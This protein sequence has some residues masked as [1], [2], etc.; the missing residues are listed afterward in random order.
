MEYNIGEIVNPKMIY[1]SGIVDDTEVYIKGTLYKQNDSKFVSVQCST[2]RRLRGNNVEFLVNNFTE[3]SITYNP[4]TRQ[5]IYRNKE[6]SPDTC[7]CLSNGNEFRA[8]FPFDSDDYIIY[9]CDMQ[10]SEDETSMI[11]SKT[12]NLRFNGTSMCL[13][14]VLFCKIMDL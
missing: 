1:F 3:V 11:F 12:A 8:T 6:C 13:S 7:S 2:C 9:S 4:V 10:F 5:C 14:L